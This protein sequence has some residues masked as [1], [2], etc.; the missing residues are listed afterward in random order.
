MPKGIKVI[1]IINT[2]FLL[3]NL[4]LV[5]IVAD[6]LSRYVLMANCVAWTLCGPLLWV[7]SKYVWMLARPLIYGWALLTVFGMLMGDWASLIISL[8]T[9]IPFLVYIIGVRGYLN[10]DHVRAY[11]GVPP[12]EV[13]TTQE[14]ETAP[15]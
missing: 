1:S 3:L 12:S 10:E 9:G 14:D 13:K 6:D 4:V 2:V 8:I 15:A 5:I 7:R 11:F